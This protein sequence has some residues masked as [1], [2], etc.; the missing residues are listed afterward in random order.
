MPGALTQTMWSALVI[1]VGRIV[2]LGFEDEESTKGWMAAFEHMH[3]SRYSPAEITD[4]EDLIKVRIFLPQYLILMLTPTLQEIEPLVTETERL[5][6]IRWQAIVAS[7]KQSGF[8]AG[9]ETETRQ[10]VR[11]TIPRTILIAATIAQEGYLELLRIKD[12]GGKSRKKLY[13]VL[14]P[15]YLYLFKLHMPTKLTSPPYAIVALSA[16]SSIDK[17]VED[18]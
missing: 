2:R 18:K 6:A 5:N 14:F 9:S 17:S 7:L 12:K 8:F 1:G 13:G 16:I 4:K 11:K 15:D 10:K 3:Q